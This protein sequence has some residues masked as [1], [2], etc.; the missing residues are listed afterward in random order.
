MKTI[1]DPLDATRVSQYR[2]VFFGSPEGLSVLED[3]LDDLGH[4]ATGP[5]PELSAEQQMVLEHAAKRILD[6]LG[7]FRVNNLD[8]YLAALKETH[9]RYY[10]VADESQE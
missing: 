2:T 9:P 1:A 7:V 6:K 10:E 8:G 4:F 5:L 3:I